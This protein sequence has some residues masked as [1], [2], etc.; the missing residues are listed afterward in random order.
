MAS[1]DEPST[2]EASSSASPSSLS[3]SWS[4]M[5]APSSSHGGTRRRET[6]GRRNISSL[7]SRRSDMHMESTG[8]E[9]G[10]GGGGE[11]NGHKANDGSLPTL[12][13]HLATED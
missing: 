7:V 2:R 8:L 6:G 4:V 12:L 10:E 11:K 1:I 9:K 5:S 13:H 3:V